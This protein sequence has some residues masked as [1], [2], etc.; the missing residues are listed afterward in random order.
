MELKIAVPYYQ[1]KEEFNETYINPSLLLPQLKLEA[2]DTYDENLHFPLML[3]LEK[4]GSRD[5]TPESR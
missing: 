2:S 3:T 4:T 1:L 5:V